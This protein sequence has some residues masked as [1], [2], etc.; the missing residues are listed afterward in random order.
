MNRHKINCLSK[1]FDTKYGK[2]SIVEIE[3]E[4][5]FRHSPTPASFLYLGRCLADGRPE[6]LIG[7]TYYGKVKGLGEFIHES[8]LGEEV[9]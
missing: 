1:Y 8:E 4:L 9:K 7:K 3:E 6:L 2:G 5:D